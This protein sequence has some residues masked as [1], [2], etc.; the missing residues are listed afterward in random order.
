MQSTN[1]N[2]SLIRPVYKG[3]RFPLVGNWFSISA[4]AR[5]L[6][7]CS[8]SYITWLVIPIVV[9][10]VNG[11]FGRWRLT[12]IGEKGFKRCTP[13]LVNSNT[14]TAVLQKSMIAWVLTSPN[15]TAPSPIFFCSLSNARLTMSSIRNFARLC[16]ALF[17]QTST[18]GCVSSLE[19]PSSDDNLISTGAYTN[20][21]FV[22]S[23]HGDGTWRWRYNRKST[24]LFIGEVMIFFHNL[25]IPC[26]SWCVK[27][28]E[29]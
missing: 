12:N 9:N 7:P 18:T 28:R 8:P 26:N 6:L 25:I 14:T 19:G 24:K 23:L 22:S 13:L 29:T 11:I 4:I 27:L 3:L 15:H 21:V 17:L 16:S 1:M 20:P 10:A 5:L 2:T